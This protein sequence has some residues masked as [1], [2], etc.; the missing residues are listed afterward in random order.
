MQARIL[1]V[2]DD[3]R[4]GAQVVVALRSAGHH[5]TWRKDGDAAML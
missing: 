1:V 4:L 5:V 3:E 2:E